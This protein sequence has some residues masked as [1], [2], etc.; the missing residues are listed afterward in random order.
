MVFFR[1]FLRK[2]VEKFLSL[3]LPCYINGNIS[4]Q[5]QNDFYI[6]LKQNKS[7]FKPGS[8]LLVKVN[9]IRIKIMLPMI[10]K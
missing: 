8:T 4:L 3:E 1:F 6:R 9:S 10:F 7:V 5:K 2:S